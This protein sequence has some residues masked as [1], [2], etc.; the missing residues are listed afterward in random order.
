M[1]R[2]A[3]GAEVGTER[4]R[5]IWSGAAEVDLMRA[6]LVLPSLDDSDLLSSIAFWKHHIPC[7]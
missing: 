1:G 4:Q 2:N 7:S 3:G 6:L 5:F